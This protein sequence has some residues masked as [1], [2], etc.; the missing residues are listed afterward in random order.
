MSGLQNQKLVAGVR[1]ELTTFG[2]SSSGA[3]YR[4]SQEIVSP[5]LRAH[6]SYKRK[7]AGCLMS[8]L[9]NQKLVAGVRF[10]LTTF[11]L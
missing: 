7:K 2:P 8:G 6:S 3:F 11:G 9:Q 5:V 1:F 10:E 4:N